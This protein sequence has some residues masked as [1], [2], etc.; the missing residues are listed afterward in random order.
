[1]TGLIVPATGWCDLLHCWLDGR[2]KLTE[3]WGVRKHTELHGVELARGRGSYCASDEQERVFKN[4]GIRLRA[5]DLMLAALADC[6]GLIVTT[7]CSPTAHMPTA[8][9]RFVEH[10]EGWAR[11][12]DSHVLVVLDG[13]QGPLDTTGVPS[14]K[15]EAAVQV[16]HRNAMPYRRVHR[17]LEL[18]RRRVIEDPI[19]QDSRSSQLIQA[20]DL[21]AYAATH[22][23]W[24]NTTIWPRGQ[25]HGEPLSELAVSYQRLAKRWLP[26]GDHGIHLLD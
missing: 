23:L 2:R 13:Q 8:Y 25:H 20:A 18:R 6:D 21:V 17:G 26:G 7:V 5:Y 19:V 1:V 3:T 9:A 24:S 16:A 4:R 12:L 15:V 11:D 10:L 14:E 22:W